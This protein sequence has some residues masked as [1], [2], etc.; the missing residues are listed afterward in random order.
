MTFINPKTD[1]AFKKIFGS[2]QSKDILINFLNAILY[3]EKTVILDLEIIDPYQAPRI[4]GIKDSYLDVK[5][6][7]T[8]NKTVIIEM[9]VLNVLGIDKRVLYNAAKAFSIQLR[10][11]ED[12]TLLNPVI[13]LTITDFDMFEG[14]N[15]VIS[16]YRL[17]EKDDFT[18]Y[19]DDIELVFV[20]LP[21]FTKQLSELET[22]S[23]K[24]LYFL[25]A[26]NTLKSVPP[27]LEEV[28]EINHA[29]EVARES[30]LTPKELEA[31]EKR[32][33]F[34]HDSKNAIL[35]AKQDGEAKGR[36][37][38]AKEKAIEIARSLIGI[39]DIQTISQTTGL[40][41]AEIEQLRN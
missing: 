29:F 8:G 3:Q 19:S 11:G 7:I 28:P 30:K 22:L 1:F 16:R 2:K 33:I 32:E 39:L 37:E 38:G 5:A 13:A 25:K 12:Y 20:E 14:N 6:T 21:K 41:V 17:K 23:D 4:K 31:L 10:V 9:Q 27:S 18:D 24:W 35:K 15:K 40:S 36:R 26:A 34:L